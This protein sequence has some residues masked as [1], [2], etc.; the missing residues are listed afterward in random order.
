M[1]II[2]FEHAMIP[3][4]SLL[5][6]ANFRKQRQITP[7]LP[8]LLEDPQRV[9]ENLIKLVEAGPAFAAV[10]NGRLVGYL[11]G[12]LVDRFRGTLR[13]GAYVPEWGHA[14]VSGSRGV[15][16]RAT[17]YRR[18]YR[19]AAGQWAEAGC[20]V[21]ALTYL[22]HD[23][24]AER[25]WFWNGFGLTVVDAI[26]PMAPINVTAGGGLRIR[27]AAASDA[28]LLAELDAEHGQHYTHSPIFMA[29]RLSDDAAA[30]IQ[31]LSQPRNSVWLAYDN[32]TLAGFM[33][34]DG[35]D[36]DSVA[37]VESTAGVL[38][39]GAYM[40]PE[41]RGQGAALALLQAALEDYQQRG[42]S[43]CAVN[44]ESFNPEAVAF[45]MKYFE[46]VCFSVTRVPEA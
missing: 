14:A 45:W 35:Y 16:T 46:P 23:R 15:P 18:L 17:T 37:A 4:A 36:F 5:F 7:L 6:A 1:E 20:Q 25:T 9:Q 39:T 2:E 32:E 24:E 10:D 27:P 11:G 21:H 44:F 8:D 12:F 33:R 29:P 42:L 30:N 43:Y 40:R 13:K 31:F 28:A 19:A 38:I 26:R 34:F 41:Y 22:A 3:A